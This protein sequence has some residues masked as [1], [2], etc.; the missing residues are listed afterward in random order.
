[1][2]CYVIGDIHGCLEELACLVDQIPIEKDDR[3]IF[4]GDYVDRGP[5]SKGV[6]SYLL[7]VEKRPVREV[8]FLKGNHEDMFMSFL[9]LEGR[10]GN[11]FLHN[12]GGSTL[13]SYGIPTERASRKDNLAV[14]P[15]SHVAF[16]TGLKKYHVV[17]PFLCVHAG[18]QPTKPLE[19]QSD[20]ELFW[21]RDEFIL[22]RHRLPYTVLFGHTPQREVLYHLPFK[23]GLD[24]GLVYGNKLSC[25]E[26]E[27]KVLFQI[28]RGSRRITRTLAKSRWDKSPPLPTP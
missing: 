2:A 1:M 17:E 27:E 16:L 21:I 23:I 25:L 9:G 11:M 10:H 5:N 13:A 20:E 24:T 12:G 15:Q 19:Q 26:I 8:V 4:L 14:I 3:V 28:S 6:I 18:V 7:D 22:N